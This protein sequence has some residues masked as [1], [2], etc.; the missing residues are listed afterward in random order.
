MEDDFEII[1][2]TAEGKDNFGH[3]YGSQ[4]YQISHKSINAL[5]EGK[6]LAATVNGNEY[7]I[8]IE[9]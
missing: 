5:L 1:E 8:F 3:C 2:N 4:T 9:L 7:T 6:A